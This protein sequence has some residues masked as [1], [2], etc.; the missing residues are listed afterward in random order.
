MERGAAV[1]EPDYI[2]D[3]CRVWPIPMFLDVY[4]VG[5]VLRSWVDLTAALQLDRSA[6]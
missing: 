3:D 6:R 2:G 1:N 4:L 5:D